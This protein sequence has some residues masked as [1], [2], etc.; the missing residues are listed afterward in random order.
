NEEDR[1]ERLEVAEEPGPRRAHPVD[2]GEPEDVG[3]EQ[4]PDDGVAEAEPYLP[5]E[6]ELLLPELGNAD[7]RER[8]PADREHERADAEGGVAPHERGDGRRVAGPREGERDRDQRP[9]EARADGT[10]SAGDQRDTAERER[11]ADA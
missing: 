5:A 4:R 10:R 7:E 1:E 11:R 2:G 6:R 9:G 8:H 3:Q